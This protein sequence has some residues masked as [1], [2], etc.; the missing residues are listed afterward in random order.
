MNKSQ[1][2]IL[3]IPKI[4]Q[5]LRDLVIGDGSNGQNTDESDAFY[6]VSEQPD[7]SAF[8]ELSESVESFTEAKNSQT[9]EETYEILQAA[10]KEMDRLLEENQRKAAELFEQARLDGFNKGI[11][12]VEEMKKSYKVT[13]M[14]A[15]QAESKK[16][17][18]EF[19]K[20][21]EGLEEEFLDLSM[22]IAKKMIKFELSRND[23]AMQAVVQ[24]AL[25]QIRVKHGITIK[26]SKDVCSG[27]KNMESLKVENVQIVP[28]DGW[29]NFACQIESIFGTLDLG[30]DKKMERISQMFCGELV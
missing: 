21:M 24:D 19:E 4:S 1:P 15:C 20:K 11:A 29:A 14:N 17:E 10:K 3:N 2:V 22:F 12:E 25:N 8:S 18:A 26:G 13:L 28:Q 16:L 5:G 6:Y 9:R 27:I 7:L 23:E 30:L